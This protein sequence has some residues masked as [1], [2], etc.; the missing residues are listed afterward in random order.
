MSWLI[1]FISINGTMTVS[2]VSD[3]SFRGYSND[4]AF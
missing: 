3:I 2:H 4:I 1:L